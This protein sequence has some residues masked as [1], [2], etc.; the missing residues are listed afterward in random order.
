VTLTVLVGAGYMFPLYLVGALGPVIRRDLELSPA[1]LGA[2]VSMFFG[3]GA[4]LL[5]FGGRLVDRM[6]PKRSI[7]VSLT[8]AAIC[9]LA[10]ATLGGS[11][12]GL[13]VAM[14]IGGLASAV[15][16]PVGGMVIARAVPAAR[17]PMAFA[18]ERSSI[19]AATLVAGLCVPIVATALPWRAVF[20]IGALL[21]LLVLLLR[22][23][24]VPEPLGPVGPDARIRP[25]GPLLLVV[26]MFV[27]GSAAATALSTF[28]VDYGVRVGTTAGTAGLVLSATSGAT[29]AVR[30]VLGALGHRAPGR[31]A[32]TILLAGGA[33]GF[34]LL[35]LGGPL[36]F[37]TGALLAGAA[38]W[39]WTGVLG[40][41]VVQS[42]PG[43][44]GAA[45]SLVQAGGCVGG[46][47]GPLLFG[48]LIEGPGYATAWLLLAGSALVA[49]GVA[50]GNRGIWQS[51]SGRPVDLVDVNHLS[52]ER[53]A[54][55]DSGTTTGTAVD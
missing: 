40:V 24:D 8:G 17:R 9:L 41:A 13:L 31:A 35:A 44:P 28:L 19:P 3:T 10:V 32:G 52:S 21:V 6:G 43:A 23:P 4:P 46:I 50:I 11:H 33:C 22:V 12:L 27:L 38:G 37:V 45:T 54:V 51:A 16:A 48:R 55:I 39:G 1:Q 30:L 34:V 20:G 49:G 53:T 5:F 42:H 25:L 26:L 29:I 36:G 2:L 15:A 18:F 14:A 47:A 7:K